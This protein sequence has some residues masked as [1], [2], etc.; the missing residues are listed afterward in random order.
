[1]TIHKIL[2]Y[3]A[4]VI[5]V[6]GLI[7]LGRIIMTG[8]DA[9]ESSASVQASVVDPFMIVAYIVFAIVLVLVLFYVI[10]GLF[11]GNIKRTLI[12]VGAFILV[13][14]IA[15][16]VTSGTEVVT[17]DGEVFSANQIH[18]VGAGLVTFY[19]LAA[20]AIGAMVL[21]GV[22]KLIK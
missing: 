20:I 4:L 15:Y 7:L 17:R 2:K 22:K 1:M 8:D 14:A 18:W 5:G 11:T 9:I 16:F 19:I 12:S 3:L 6:I 13:V 21:S 10:K